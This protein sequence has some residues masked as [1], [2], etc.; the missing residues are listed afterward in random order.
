MKKPRT[1]NLMLQSDPKQSKLKPLGGG[2]AE[3]W[4]RRLNDPTVNALPIAHSKSKEAITSAAVAVC[5]GTMDISPADPV[6][7]ILIAQLMA[8]NEAS[9]AMYSKAWAQP[10]EFYQARTKYL[11]LADKAARTVMMLTERL[12][13]HRGR[14]QQHITVKH[15]T[16]NNVT[17]DQAIVADSVTT[18]SATRGRDTSPML[19]TARSE[20][21]LPDLIEPRPDLV[22]AGGGIKAK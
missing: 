16:T 19:I 22:E 15:V 3:E 12:D 21:P 14:G 6:E 10:P 4:N 1:I 8:A 2:N 20:K 13:H 17:A 7:G 18:G 9:L 11:Q 5:R